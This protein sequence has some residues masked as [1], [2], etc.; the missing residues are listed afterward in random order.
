MGP[1]VL[2]GLETGSHFSTMPNYDLI[3]NNLIVHNLLINYLNKR[4][5]K[6][7]AVLR[8]SLDNFSKNFV[9]FYR[10]HQWWRLDTFIFLIHTGLILTNDCVRYPH[11][12]PFLRNRAP[13][14]LLKPSKTH[15]VLGDVAI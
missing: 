14:S 12:V 8:C 1:V 10:K 15:A 7:A 3:E 9:N 2:E 13:F 6:K 5:N 11:A 4:V